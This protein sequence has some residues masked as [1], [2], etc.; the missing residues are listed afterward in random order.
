MAGSEGEARPS[1]PLQWPLVER[2]DEL[3]Q[4][5]ATLADPRAH[6]FVIHGPAGVGKTRLADQCLAA[7]AAAGRAVARA[8]ASEAAGAVPLGA[9]A[10]LLPPGLG[11]RR[12]D[13]VAVVAE[14]RA[15]LE[16]NDEPLVLFVDDL[17]LLDPT[18]AT[19]LAQLVD[20]DLVFLV[21]TV[22]AGEPLPRV[23]D[24]LW[25]R[26]RVRRVDLPDLTA[27]GLDTLLHLVLQGPVEAS[28][29]NEIA[30][31]SEGNVLFVREL[32]LGAL[33]QGHLVEQHGVWRLVQP[34]TAT[35]R[36]V[37]VV[38]ARLGGL[39]RVTLD[40]LEAIAVWEPVSISVLESA[41]DAR[42][43][44]TL[45]RLGF[46]TMRT[47][48]RRRR[49]S[50]AHPLYGEIVRER[51]P[52]LT[53]RRLLLEK[54]DRI[55]AN[56]ARRREDPITVANA[57]LEATGSADPRLLLSAA[58]LARYG[59]DAHQVARLGRAALA[60]GITSEGGL[61]VGEACHELA[62][63]EEAEAV[64]S[65]AVDGTADDDELF[66]PLVEMRS[67]NLMW[68]L[69]RHEDAIAVNDDAR[70]RLDDGPGAVRLDLNKA[71]LLTY[72]DRPVEGL[73]LLAQVGEVEPPAARA[74]RSV[75]EVTAL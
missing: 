49:V 28:T 14:V 22:R 51:T 45:D 59:Q 21:G 65:A 46:L 18:S 36:L 30:T 33:D 63:Y 44:E 20:A 73:A 74:L 10:H 7:A 64:L 39:D 66:V 61:L 32:V 25:Q 52:A 11:D 53:R 55:D 15:V 72:T 67:R 13:L 27:A 41:L 40:A 75:S 8:T 3:E 38:A 68:G 26:A 9:L 34:L 58:R 50:L 37:E 5:A 1:V 56:G 60:D 6:G 17:Q 4:F 23:L 29:I 43:L 31:R 57:R 12:S 42:A 16:D 71:M 48:G 69:F 24:G 47:D 70:S 54:A 19:L 2:H 35:P 62:R